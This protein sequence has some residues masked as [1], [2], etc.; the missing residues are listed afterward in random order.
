MTTA[1][2]LSDWGTQGEMRT[3]DFSKGDSHSSATWTTADSGLSKLL[4]NEKSRV[5]TDISPLLNTASK[6]I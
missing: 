5:F 6:K 3:G 4:K 1:T 2:G